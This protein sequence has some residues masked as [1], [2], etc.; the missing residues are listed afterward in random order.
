MDPSTS[1]EGAAGPQGDERGPGALERLASFR[2]TYF[3]FCAFVVLYVFSVR[4][5]E[6][7][8]ARRVG[9]D[10]AR[11]VELDPAGGPVQPRIEQRVGDLLASRVWTRVAGV[12][13]EP[14]VVAADGATL[15]YPAT[16]RSSAAD[17]QDAEA[18]AAL[19]PARTYAF[20]AVPH[21]SLAANAVLVSYA[22]VLL[23][24]L[25][26]Y[27]RVMTRR[28]AERLAGAL[29]ARD[30]LALRASSIEGELAAVRERL[31]RA[32]PAH[33][34]DAAQVQ[35]LRSERGA[36][37]ER[38]AE[39][40]GREAALLAQGARAD[41]LQAEHQTLETLLDEALADLDR[42]ER[43]LRSL[44][45]TARQSVRAAGREADRL[46]RRFAALYKNLEMDERALADLAGLGDEALALRAEEGLKRLSDESEQ[47]A[48]RRKVGG[49][50]P[51][52]SI[53]ELGFGGRGR[54]YYTR[55][56]TRRFRV[57]LV[58]D[59]ASQKTDL[60]YLSRLPREA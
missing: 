42:K 12:R 10:L 27:T 39:L 15:L 60:E 36:L 14:L 17:A 29:A 23:S 30:A 38:L 52:L 54:V 21:N 19:L 50:P 41:S 24:V 7:S 1:A 4:A 35:A 25:F 9:A 16:P 56:R 45:K 57:L 53:F 40:E 43:E 34:A 32:E 5:L 47:A 48:V 3:A 59:K 18:D 37:L 46:A 49:L 51:H 22:G 58:G 26:A 44:Q 6:D 55:G 13:I 28:E 33:E 11:A 8:L 31:G 2:F 20:V